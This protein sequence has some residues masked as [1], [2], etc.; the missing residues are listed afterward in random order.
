MLDGVGSFKILD[1]AKDEYLIRSILEGDTVI[2]GFSD[3]VPLE[4]LGIAVYFYDPN[5]GLFPARV[6][7]KHI[8]I[9]AAIPKE[10]RGRAAVES[11]R[12]LAKVLTS[13]GLNVQSR[14]KHNNKH[15]I[16]FARAVGMTHIYNNDTHKIYRY[17]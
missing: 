16:R 15:V 1:P 10:N 8:D 2:D 6:K 17:L 13:F 14:I 11:A 5:V 7:G 4:D 9:H 3:G 12:C